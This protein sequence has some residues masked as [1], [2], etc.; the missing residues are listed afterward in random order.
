MQLG[1]RAIHHLAFSPPQRRVLFVLLAILIVVCGV[2]YVLNRRTIPDP[3]QEFGER[4]SELADKIDINT[5]DWPT[6]AALPAI[7]EKRARDIVAYR[8]RVH[9]RDPAAVP[10]RKPEDLLKVDGIGYVMMQR[11]TPYLV[12]PGAPATQP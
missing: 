9:D 12:F 11:L 5:A 3:Q 10:F 6:L 1:E 8:Q 7:G 4:A 2:S